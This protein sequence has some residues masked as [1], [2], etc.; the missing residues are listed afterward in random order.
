MAADT[1]ELSPGERQA[2]FYKTSI[3]TVE[4]LK[5]HITDVLEEEIWEG[6]TPDPSFRYYFGRY[7]D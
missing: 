1:L 7:L 6:I 4:Q 5:H 3:T 2:I